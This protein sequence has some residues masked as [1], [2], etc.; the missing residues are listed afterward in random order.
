MRICS[1]ELGVLMIPPHPQQ[2]PIPF[3]A[4]PRPYEGIGEV[5]VLDRIRCDEP[6][7]AR[8]LLMAKL[9]KV[10]CTLVVNTWVKFILGC[11]CAVRTTSSATLALALHPRPRP[12]PHPRPRSQPPPRSRFPS[13]LRSTTLSV[14]FSTDSRVAQG[15]SMVSRV[16]S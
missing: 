12:H 1:Y 8:E 2:F 3:G 9:V 5:V 6:T 11:T 14:S 13:C 7:P 10:G 16:S 15:E 4:S